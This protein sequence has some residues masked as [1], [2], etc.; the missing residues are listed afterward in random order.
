MEMGPRK[1]RK[2]RMQQELVELTAKIE[3]LGTF[4]TTERFAK[5]P[6]LQQ[7]LLIGQLKAMHT[8]RELLD[9]RL[10]TDDFEGDY[11]QE[12]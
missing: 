2:Q 11:P 3:A 6:H 10:D 9:L 8:Y 4:L 5:I 12:D 7:K 1:T